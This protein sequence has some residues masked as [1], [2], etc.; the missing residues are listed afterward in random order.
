MAKGLDLDPA[1]YWNWFQAIPL[2]LYCGDQVSYR[3][4]C[5]AVLEQFG[6]TGEALIA[7]RIARVC[8]L[9]SSPVEDRKR[10]C[11][12]ADRAVASH[13]G[14]YYIPLFGATK[15]MA[16]YRDGRLHSAIQ[17]L[18]KNTGL[19]DR[20]MAPAIQSFLAMAYHRLGQSDKARQALEKANQLRAQLS[21]HVGEVNEISGFQ[22]WMIGQISYREAAALLDV[23]YRKAAEA[24]L[25]KHEWSPAA[26]ELEHLIEID[27]GFWPDWVARSCANA[28]LGRYESA[29]ADFAHALVLARNEPYP[30]LQRGRF[31]ME[32]GRPD[33]AAVDFAR[34]S[35]S[36]RMAAAGRSRAARSARTCSPR[37]PSSPRSWRSDPKTAIFT[38]PRPVSRQDKDMGQGPGR[39]RPCRA[40]ETGRPHPSTRARRLSG[41]S[42]PMG[43]GRGG[44]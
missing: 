39:L 16:E 9:M 8:L 32:M 22:D 37:S 18:Q 13:Y 7:D 41:K 10:L 17:W 30:W 25:Q 26:L 27:S 24:S 29:D 6:D 36:C 33:K 20:N 14:A 28:E 15:G 11:E 44:L 4:L 34:R 5:R 31:H 23:P 35:S 42:G 12:L 43:Q 3:R 19:A 40:F 21:E 1:H 38:S 2:Q